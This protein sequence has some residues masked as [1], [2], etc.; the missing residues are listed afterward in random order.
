MPKS[1]RVLIAV[2]TGII[3][4]L[5]GVILY[6]VRDKGMA[7]TP[8]T[9]TTPAAT[10]TSQQQQNTATTTDTAPFATDTTNRD[11]LIRSENFFETKRAG[12]VNLY[13]ASWVAYYE[14]SSG[15][16]FVQITSNNGVAVYS[17][18]NGYQYKLQGST[19]A[20]LR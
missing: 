19:F 17:V 10:S 12:D 15:M 5:M 7:T 1:A 8:G 9:T 11:C 2:L 6:A 3:L 18:D 16:C 14:Q 4:I 20:P 13:S